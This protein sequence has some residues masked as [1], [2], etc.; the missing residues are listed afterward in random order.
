MNKRHFNLNVN[1]GLDCYPVLGFTQDYATSCFA[2]FILSLLF[3]L[4]SVLST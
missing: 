4:M 3:K 2:K 1:F